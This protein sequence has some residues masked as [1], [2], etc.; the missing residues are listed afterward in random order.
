VVSLDGRSRSFS[1]D[2]NGYA[3]GMFY[4]C[5]FLIL[6]GNNNETRLPRFYSKDDK[7]LP[8]VLLE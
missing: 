4:R 3:K 2:A 8:L 7:F 6:E 5:L 1:A